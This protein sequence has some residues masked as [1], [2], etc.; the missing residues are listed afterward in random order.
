MVPE[1]SVLALLANEP[2]THVAKIDAALTEHF[3]ER[4]PLPKFQNGRFR[5]L[6]MVS[7]N[8]VLALLASEPHTPVAKFD[9]ACRERRDDPSERRS[10]R[11]RLALFHL[12][13]RPPMDFGT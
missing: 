1:N 3:G 8:S 5:F 6:F 9:A 13:D 12:S 4:M 10:L 7:E 2:H 11:P